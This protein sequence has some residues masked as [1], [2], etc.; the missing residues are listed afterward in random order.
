VEAR[1]LAGEVFDQIAVKCHS[2]PEVVEAYHAAFFQVR[3]RLATDYIANVVIG[4][5]RRSGLTG[6]DIDVLLKIFGYGGGPLVLDAAVRFFRRPL[7]LPL[8]FDTLDAAA[9]A[10]LRSQL[11]I[12][13]SI[14][15]LTIPADARNLRKLA[16]LQET[17]QALAGPGANEALAAGVLQ[18]A[19][20]FE[21][22]LAQ[23][24]AAPPAGASG[25]AAVVQNMEVGAG[26][27][28]RSAARREVSS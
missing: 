24:L 15:A 21:V 14:L 5:K 20:Q 11:L 27:P 26:G 1:L 8:Q 12:R 25:A 16:A 13:A 2:A 22:D 23:A 18:A 3:D 10:E 7:L 6:G 17:F 19:A 28:A 4:P 9:L